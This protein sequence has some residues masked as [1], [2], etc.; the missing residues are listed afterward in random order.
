M[1]RNKVAVFLLLL[2]LTSGMTYVAGMNKPQALPEKQEATVPAPNSTAPDKSVS[3]DKPQSS[4]TEKVPQSAR[5][6]SMQFKPETKTEEPIPNQM[7]F[8][9]TMKKEK[10]REAQLTPGIRVNSD[11]EIHMKVPNSAEDITLRRDN[12]YHSGEYRVQWDRKF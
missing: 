12:T 10:P 8:S 2:A 11:K 1:K 5:T 3:A 7:F 6:G 9:E 4:Q